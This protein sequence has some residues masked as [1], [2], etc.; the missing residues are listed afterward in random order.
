[1]LKKHLKFPLPRFLGLKNIDF[2]SASRQIANAADDLVDR[3][4]SPAPGQALNANIEI[5]IN[6]NRPVMW[7]LKKPDHQRIIYLRTWL[8]PTGYS[9]VLIRKPEEYLR[10][11]Q[12]TF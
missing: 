4:Q 3:W 9:S 8:E 1:M 7:E 6:K 5:R 12:V 11:N 2:S 10:E